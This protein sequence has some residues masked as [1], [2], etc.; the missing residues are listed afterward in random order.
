[1]SASQIKAQAIKDCETLCSEI[2]GC[3]AVDVSVPPTLMEDIIAGKMT[4]MEGIR[5][6]KLH[7]CP[8]GN[9]PWMRELK[10]LSRHFHDLQRF[11]TPEVNIDSLLSTISRKGRVDVEELKEAVKVQMKYLGE[12]E[13][14]SPT[15][16]IRNLVGQFDFP[17]IR[18]M[19]TLS[20]MF[21][22]IHFKAFPSQRKAKPM[23]PKP[24]KPTT[25]PLA[26]ETAKVVEAAAVEAKVV[27]AT[28]G[29][30]SWVEVTK[31]GRVNEP[32]EEEVSFPKLPEVADDKPSPVDLGAS[33]LRWQLKKV[34]QEADEATAR[35]QAELKSL[36]DAVEK[37][38]DEV[39]FMNEVGDVDWDGL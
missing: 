8:S 35:L 14:W 4:P 17:Y 21:H 6:F 34:K 29:A 15:G 22:D 27:E 39:P 3:L 1:M 25:S 13:N 32:K 37:N 7:C 9:F 33:L 16:A 23:R 36:H 10:D 5:R 19:K 38:G 28:A 11:H 24:F 2:I 30:G 12:R 20:R 26:E 18:E 31:K